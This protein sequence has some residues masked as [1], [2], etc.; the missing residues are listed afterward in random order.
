V[1]HGLRNG[2][3]LVVD[4]ADYAAPLREVRASF[5]TLR[6][7][8]ALRGC[9]GHL[10][11]DQALVVDVAENAHRSAFGDLRF[12]PLGAD[13]LR[14]LEIHISVLGPLEPFPADSERTLLERLRPGIDG[15]VLR[16]G[17]H[18]ATFL[19]SVWESI[20]EP[21]DFL[22]ELERKA[23][24]PPGHWSTTLRFERYEALQI[25]EKA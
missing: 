20:T 19:P 18:A 4:P 24:L 7:G 3:P 8:G 21:R 15:L 14:E 11:A 23:G 22:H 2:G 13:E 6:V 25:S 10:E 17:A 1:E 9:T 5:V 16:D 12:E